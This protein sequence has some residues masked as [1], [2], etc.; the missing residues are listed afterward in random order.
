[1]CG[2]A[3]IFSFHS[4]APSIDRA[5]L[6]RIRDYMR[7]RGPDLKGEWY[8]DDGRLGIG[9]RRLSIIDLSER[10]VQPM[11]NPSGNLVLSFNGEIYNYRSLRTFL[12][13]QGRVFRSTTDTEV[14]LQL[15]ELKG[16]AMFNDLRGMFALLHHGRTPETQSRARSNSG[17]NRPSGQLLGLSWSVSRR[18][19]TI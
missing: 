4:A 17:S 10:G 11:L 12:E 1:M 7:V 15:Y 3:A 19:I 2:V 8:S 13:G 6:V 9:H 16:E 18:A 14:I 5:E